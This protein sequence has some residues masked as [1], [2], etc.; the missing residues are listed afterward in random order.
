MSGLL[1]NFRRGP[2]TIAGLCLLPVL[3]LLLAVPASAQFYFGK[4][5]VNYTQFDWQVM[6]TEHF[7]IYFYTAGE[8]I[9]KI[10]AHEAETSYEALAMDFNHEVPDKI[11]LIIYSAPNYFSQ[12]NILP[13]LIPEGVA[14]FTEFMKGRVVVPFHGS[15]HDFAHVIRHE[16][17]HVFTI[18]KLGSVVD[19]QSRIRYGYPPLWF[20]EGIA[21]YWSKDWDTE[22]DMIIKDM[23]VTNNLLPITEL[24]RIRGTYYM[25]KLG[26]SICTFIDTTY[27]EDKLLLIF[28]NWHKGR[29]FDE[30]VE[31]VTGDDLR[32]LSR[33]WEYSLKKKYFPEIADLDLPK[34]RSERITPDGY[35]VKGVPIRWD[36]GK[37]ERDWIVFKANRVGYSGI[38]MKPARPGK[39]G[40]KTL[41]KGERSSKFESLYLLRSGI[42]A[43]SDGKVVFSSKSKEKDVINLYDL[44]EGKVT[45][46]YG[47]DSLVAARS[48]QF[49]PD[50]RT[51]VFSGMKMSGFSDLYLLDLESGE[52]EAI[53]ADIFYDIDP[54]FSHDG[55]AVVFSSDRAEDG[56]QG[57]LNLFKIDLASHEL[58]QVTYGPY[59]DQSPEVTAEGI[60]FS[61]DR[62][63]SFNLFL[64]EENGA[65]TR[66]S[67]YITGAFDPRLSPDGNHLTYTG[68]QDGA[69]Q[70]YRMD[71][72]TD[73]QPIAHDIAPGIA[74][75]APSKIE[76]KY[77]ASSIKYDTEYSFDIAQSTVVYDP[78]Y[79]SAGG[80]QVALSDIL[81]NHVYYMLLTNTADNKDEILSSFNLGVTY[82]NK[83]R[84]LNW[85]VGLF[86]LYDEYF[87][88]F[89]QY[90]DERQAGGLGFL[91]YP[92]SKFQRVEFATYARYSKKDRRFGLTDREGFLT[93]NQLRWVYDNSFWDVSG[94]IE[95]RRYNITVGLTTSLTE[96]RNY[97]RQ[98][99]IDLR[100]YFRLGRVSAFANRLFA[101]S[102]SGI[103]PQRIYFGGSWSFRGFDRREWYVRNVLFMSNELRF[104]LI[105][106][107]FIGFP[108]GGLGF[109]GI[110]GALFFD[111]GSAWEDE[112]DQFLGSFGF[113]F[114]VSLGYV[115]LLRF[116]FARTTDFETISDKWDFDFFFGWN[117]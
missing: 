92:I 107:L 60:Y 26:E 108:I 115:L 68:Y 13:Q 81:G 23:V 63:G 3:A 104:P 22:A 71:L 84:Q 50:G 38:Y 21:E 17:V 117:F 64:L 34:M 99:L 33:K 6:T 27:G 98:A 109:R 73:P 20:T 51:V 101:Y 88:D 111:T 44:D 54:T 57:A 19:R 42:D 83:E 87:N 61:S 74:K 90:Y 72:A 28:E 1:S 91:S 85:G 93:T 18:S 106:N 82:V 40:I 114:R 7:R 32:E 14:G 24:W 11:P 95:G 112:F 102:S 30:V 25:Y 94:P 113:G 8:E 48:P 96:G 80:L 105:D 45:R 9:A 31:V 37:G 59:K 29:S 58:T 47:F 52:I 36:D 69:F 49:S 2:R 5:K 41:V 35:A 62:E 43:T 78:V 12:T 66:Q 76:R 53:T 86:H 67:T 77:S 97:S 46:R 103:E 89:D 79:G 15:Y 75:W 70:V 110:R 65:L 100:H 116:D 10:A 56:K 39:D 55:S 4:N 16:L